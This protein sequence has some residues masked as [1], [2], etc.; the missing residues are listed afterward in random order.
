MV[1][2]VVP[3]VRNG[4]AEPLTLSDAWPGGPIALTDADDKFVR[5]RSTPETLRH[6]FADHPFRRYAYAI[7]RRDDTIDGLVVYRRV[8]LRGL[9]A[10]SLLAAYGAD[11]PGL[12]AGWGAALRHAGLH[13]VH[14]VTTPASPI[15]DAVGAIG[16]RLPVPVSRNPYHLIARALQPDT[17]GILF[18]LGRWDAT[19]GDIL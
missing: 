15:R 14:V 13:L 19:G 17:P 4:R 12:L 2:I 7:R 1:S 3:V 6:R 9:P 16:P 5:Y 11:Q 18:D 8:R 10:A